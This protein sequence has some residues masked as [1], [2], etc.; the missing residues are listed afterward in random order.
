MKKEIKTKA[1]VSDGGQLMLPRSVVQGVAAQFS[2]RDVYVTIEDA[3]SMRTPNQNGYYWA[4]IVKEITDEF[5]DRGERFFPGQV[6]QMLKFMFLKVSVFDEE[7]GEILFEYVRS[8]K[9]LKV[10]EMC[11]YIEDC[12]RYAAETLEL[13]IKPPRARRTDYI[14]PIF[15]K[16]K[17]LREKYMERITSYLKDIYSLESLKRFFDQNEEWAT[18]DEIRALFTNRKFEI[19]QLKARA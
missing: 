5:N 18:D 3:E 8:T 6:H 9:D 2:G 14:F 16:K 10:Y 11:F 4:A 15:P 19:N 7:H 13:V 12:I 17:E 1:F